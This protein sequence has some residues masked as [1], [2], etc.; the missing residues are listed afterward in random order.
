[1]GHQPKPRSIEAGLPT[2]HPKKE[3]E[4]WRRSGGKVIKGD[5]SRASQLS[6]N[7]RKEFRAMRIIDERNYWSEIT[8]TRPLK[9]SKLTSGKAVQ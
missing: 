6:E 5:K 2:E 8:P 7:F 3:K 1:M 9:V 4:D